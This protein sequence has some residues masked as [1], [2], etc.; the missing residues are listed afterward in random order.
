[1]N[2]HASVHDGDDDDDN[3]NNPND[4]DDNNDDDPN[5]A[6]DFN[7]IAHIAGV[8]NEENGNADQDNEIP[9]VDEEN[10]NGDG[11]EIP[12]VDE[13]TANDDGNQNENAD[14]DQNDEDEDNKELKS[15]M[16]KSMAKEWDGTIFDKEKH[17][18]FH[19]CSPLK[20]MTTYS[21]SRR[22]PKMTTKAT[23]WK[24]HK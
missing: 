9:G 2:T 11:N 14:G 16:D 8:N 23:C 21:P 6:A 19:V 5:D 3:D 12:G 1:M 15:E 24:H 7:N 17:A 10:A 18:I 13:E 20:K 4:D 22:P